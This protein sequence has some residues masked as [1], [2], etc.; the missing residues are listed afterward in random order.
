MRAVVLVVRLA[1]LALETSL[2]LS[3]NADSVADLTGGNLAASLDY[4]ANDFMTNA[5]W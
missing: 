1:N 3:T 5:N 2:D 4:F